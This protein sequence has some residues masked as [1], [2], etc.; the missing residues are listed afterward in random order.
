MKFLLGLI[1]IGATLNAPP[2]QA[3]ERDF[4]PLKHSYSVKRASDIDVISA[5]DV[6]EVRMKNLFREEFRK[7]VI[8]TMSECIKSDPIVRKSRANSGVRIFY[9]ILSNG[10]SSFDFR[11]PVNNPATLKLF[12]RLNSLLSKGSFCQI[13]ESQGEAFGGWVSL[14][15]LFQ[16]P[17][18][19]KLLSKDFFV[20]SMEI[21][22]PKQDLKTRTPVDHMAAPI[23]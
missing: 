11:S 7:H 5:D 23:F 17:S 18:E 14:P 15:E 8:S 22:K 21:A 4:E 10:S 16:W 9:Q 1:L 2:A 3:D 13:P 20:N 19:A 12:R 6:A